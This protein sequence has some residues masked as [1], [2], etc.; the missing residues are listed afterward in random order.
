VGVF[1]GW[2]D[3]FP[4]NFVATNDSALVHS[5]K[6]GVGFGAVGSL[7]DLSQRLTTTPGPKL[8][9]QLLAGQHDSRP[10]R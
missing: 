9:H 10:T 8:Q 7:S 4:D 2:T 5:G 6:F 3:G 1:S